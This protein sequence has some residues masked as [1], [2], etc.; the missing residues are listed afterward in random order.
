MRIANPKRTAQT[1]NLPHEHYCAARGK[2][3]CGTLPVSVAVTLDDGKAGT[4][5]E[6]RRVCA[7]I[8][9]LA[10]EVRDFEDAVRAAPEV[11]AALDRRDL[12]EVQS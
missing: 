3:A 12:R 11:K 4:R 7:S 10:G 8:T 6:Q 5:E 1:F 2:C 9:L